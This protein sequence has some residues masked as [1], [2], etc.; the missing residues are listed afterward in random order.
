MVCTAQQ[1]RTHIPYLPLLLLLP[2]LL[3]HCRNG[4]VLG[5]YPAFICFL[6]RED[7]HLNDSLLLT[8]SP[9]KYICHI[10]SEESPFAIPI[11]IH[12]GSR[13]SLPFPNWARPRLLCKGILRAEENISRFRA[14]SHYGLLSWPCSLKPQ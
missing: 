6:L 2:V 11:S 7:L 4:S 10:T 12:A 3:L 5:I 14:I 1:D 13:E 8:F 9:G